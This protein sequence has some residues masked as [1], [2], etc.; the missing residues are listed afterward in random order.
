MMSGHYISELGDD[1]VKD[2]WENEAGLNWTAT[3][4]YIRSVT[5]NEDDVLTSEGFIAAQF[6]YASLRDVMT[7]LFNVSC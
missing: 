1:R 4:Q 6:V 7:N 5:P 2:A 3:Q